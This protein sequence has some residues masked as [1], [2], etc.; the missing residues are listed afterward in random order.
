MNVYL[1]TS[2]VLSHF[3]AQANRLRRWGGWPR[4]YTSELTRVEFLRIV[5]RLRLDGEIDD[6]ARAGLRERF[7][8]LWAAVYIVPLSADILAR[9]A[10]PFPTVL[11]TL[12]ALHMASALV[13]RDESGEEA[14]AVLTHDRQL[15]RAATALGVGVDGI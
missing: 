5:D 10:E 14:F 3:L 7:D 2:V 8:I 13:A 6:E 4:A 12:D 11:G 1:D 15:A 9:A